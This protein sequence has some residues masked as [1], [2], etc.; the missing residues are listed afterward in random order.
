MENFNN[1]ILGYGTEYYS[2]FTIREKSK[3]V[4]LESVVKDKNLTFHGFTPKGFYDLSQIKVKKRD[5]EL[6]HHNLQNNQNTY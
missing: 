3:S 6:K 1:T 2:K 4:S 5:K